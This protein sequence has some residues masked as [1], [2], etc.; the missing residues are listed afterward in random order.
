MQEQRDIQD[1]AT[2]EVR[3]TPDHEAQES[4]ANKRTIIR[5]RYIVLG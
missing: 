1:T 5:R 2:Q 3:E 4:P